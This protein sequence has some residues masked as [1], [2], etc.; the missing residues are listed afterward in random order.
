VLAGNRTTSGTSWEQ[1]TFTQAQLAA[2]DQNAVYTL[3]AIDAGHNGG[4]CVAAWFNL[5]TVRIPGALDI[6]PPPATTIS[7]IANQTIFVNTSTGP[8]SF[9]LSDDQINPASLTVAGSSSNPGLVPQSNIVLGG[10]GANRT[11]TVTPVADQLGTA[12]ITLTVSGGTAPANTSFILSVVT[13]AVPLTYDFDDG[14]F[15]GWTTV[16]ADAQGRQFFAI[17]PPI[18]NSPNHTPQAGSHFVGLHIPAFSLNNP[19]APNYTQ[20]DPHDTLLLR[21]PEFTLNGTGNLSAWLSGGG[22]G[23]PN[24]ANTSVG[25]LPAASSSGGFRGVALRNATT[26]MFVLSGA[27]TADGNSWQQVTFNATQ[28][29]ALPQNDVYTLDLIDARHGGWGW[30]NMDSVTIPGTLVSTQGPPLTIQKWTGNQVRI[31]WPSSAT[32]YTLQSSTAVNSGYGNAGL[33]VTT[34]GS[35]FVAYATVGSGAQFYRLSK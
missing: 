31:S 17:V 13:D 27:K 23:S 8:L 1:V 5:D 21:S 12:T 18:T 10:S 9:T 19:P 24:L 2:L 28:L 35:E 11:V 3:D 6:G 32:G 26:G 22:T 33:T 34:E 15:Q 4:D 14:T 30:V 29:A 20:D 7:P 16:S 25:A